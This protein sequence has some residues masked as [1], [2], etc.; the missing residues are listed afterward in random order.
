ME[1]NLIVDNLNR[2]NTIPSDKKAK[3]GS[4]FGFGKK[5]ILQLEG[6][7][8][9]QTIVLKENAGFFSRLFARISGKVNSKK[10]NQIVNNNGFELGLLGK[11]VVDSKVLL[12]TNE[13]KLNKNFGKKPP[14]DSKL[15]DTLENIDSIELP[16]DDVAWEN[17][18]EDNNIQLAT[19]TQNGKTINWKHEKNADKYFYQKDGKTEWEEYVKPL[20]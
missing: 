17:S 6:S 5:S 9:N 14:L 15:N 16:G 7:G 8:E 19:Q 2:Y 12:V 3:V 10:I 13:L 1:P 11:T 18:S 4:W 20:I